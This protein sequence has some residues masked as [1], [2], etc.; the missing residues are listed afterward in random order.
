MHLIRIALA[1]THLSEM[2]LFYNTLFQAELKPVKS[3][4]YVFYSG[5]LGG[6][7]LTLIPNDIAQ[8]KASQNRQQLS[9]LVP[10][11]AEIL[12]MAASSGGQLLGEIIESPEGKQ[13]AVLDPDGNTI[14]FMERSAT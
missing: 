11:I 8:V 14:E 9:F 7:A 5:Q 2:V 12:A 4:N 10:S 6:I 3:G 13:A 1:V